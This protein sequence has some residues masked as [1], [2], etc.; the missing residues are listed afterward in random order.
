MVQV[1]QLF[2]KRHASHRK[3][4]TGIF[5]VIV[6]KATSKVQVTKKRRLKQLQEMLVLKTGIE[7]H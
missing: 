6:L 1:K 7:K 5:Y 3:H 4:L 2:I